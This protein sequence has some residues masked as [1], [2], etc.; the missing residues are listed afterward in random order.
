VVVGT[1][2]LLTIKPLSASMDLI[3]KRMI[4]LL[5]PPMREL[6]PVLILAAIRICLHKVLRLPLRALLPLIVKNMRFPPE[7]LP[8]VGVDT[9]VSRVLGV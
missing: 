6:A 5:L 2:R 1:V 9:G 7:I 8:V 3:V 4:L